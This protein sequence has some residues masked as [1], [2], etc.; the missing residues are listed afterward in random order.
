MAN[1]GFS[2]ETWF[3]CFGNLEEWG[4]SCICSIEQDGSEKIH[5]ILH[6]L[7]HQSEH[8]LL[9]SFLVFLF[10]PLRLV[11]FFRVESI[12]VNGTWEEAI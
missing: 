1:G 12:C 5:P 8:T 10:S 7:P 9:W 6:L 11:T 3:F 4:Y 2:Q